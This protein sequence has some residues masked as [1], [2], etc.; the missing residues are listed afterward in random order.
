V[1]RMLKWSAGLVLCVSAT[2]RAQPL[3]ERVPADALVYVGWAGASTLGDS[4]AGTH[5][6][7]VMVDSRLSDVFGRF[8]DQVEA[9]VV[10]AQ[11][12]AKEPFR[13]GRLLTAPM[14]RYPTALYVGKP[15]LSVP[16][17]PK[18]FVAMMCRA[19]ADAP[20]VAK[21]VNAL[22][23]KAGPAPVPIKCFV[24]NDI[25]CF[26]IGYE[27]DE[28]AL[29]GEG[30]DRPTPLASNARFVAA[31][32]HAVKKPALMTYVNVSGIIEAIE[33]GVLINAEDAAPQV[34]AFLDASGFRNVESY[35]DSSGFEGKDWVGQTFI[36]APGPR[37]GLLTQA[38]RR[39]IDPTL[40]QIVPA[41]AGF[42]AA[43]RFDAAASV[44]QLQE[45][46]KS[47]DP[48]FE[49]YFNMGLGALQQAVGTNVM[50]NLLEP[51]GSDWVAYA[52][53]KVSTTGILG[54]VVV[55]KL[56]DPDK[57]LKGLRTA[58]VNLSNW[59][60]LG[61]NR[62]S[63]G[64]GLMIHGASTR[65]GDVD[66]YYMALPIVAPSWA[67]KDGRLYLGLYP[68]VVG[69][70]VRQA[71]ANKQSIVDS[72]KYQSLVK[73]LGAPQV[74][75][76]SFYD[77]PA[78]I[79]YGYWYQQWLV[80]GRYAGIGDLWGLT[81]PEPLIPPFDTLRQHVDV[82]GS[83]SWSDDAGFHSKRI[84]SFPG[85][86]LLSEQGSATML[87]GVGSVALGTSILLP[88]LNRARETANR[89][90]SASNLKQIGMGV[91][92]YA[93]ENKGRLPDN[94]AELLRTQDLHHSVMLNPRSD[95]SFPN[96][97]TR[98]EANQFAADNSDYVYVGAG[99]KM[100]DI[101]ADTILAYE[102]P[103][104]LEDGINIL[105]GD[106]HIEFVRMEQAMEMIEAQQL[107]P[108]LP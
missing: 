31:M 43:G 45:T 36:S 3:A 39:P 19:G 58:S 6:Q 1:K 9:K 47:T 27:S 63:P 8:L 106:G 10:Q 65:I 82:A 107:Q 98:D 40:T 28:M 92:F 75:G 7:S 54:T 33:A 68:Q 29:A 88:S 103:D 50:T 61:I 52:A 72:E 105:F 93:N 81:L 22:I 30:G 84:V 80:L 49:R 67:I 15:D 69:S 37:I 100:V 96:E 20:V 76:V 86:L 53:P 14:W 12:Q 79:G 51:L 95:T 35:I 23:E 16:Q 46:L 42:Y 57:M 56:D 48:E 34:A 101:Q 71:S 13:I 89:V 17:A 25:V 55:N 24:L 32:K 2:L 90:T 83:V 44:K 78:S 21:E 60:N 94:F 11:P 91:M 102:R 5:L 73:R 41:D 26:S 59:I 99:K 64:S 62:N 18:V 38:A 66:V 70:A 85:A 74:E 87:S 77:L 108:A 97:L 104:G 4:Y